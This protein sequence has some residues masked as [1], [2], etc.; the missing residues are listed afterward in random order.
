MG[1]QSNSRPNRNL[2]NA[3]S[4]DQECTG[5]DWCPE[6]QEQDATASPE[7]AWAAAL[8][9]RLAPSPVAGE[10]PQGGDTAPEYFKDSYHGLPPEPTAVRVDAGASEC[11]QWCNE[12]IQGNGVPA[13]L[14]GNAQCAG[15][16]FCG[17]DDPASNATD[18]NATVTNATD[19]VDQLA[20]RLANAA[21]AGAHKGGRFEET[22]SLAPRPMDAVS[23]AGVLGEPTPPLGI[24]RAGSDHE[25]SPER[26]L[27][28]RLVAREVAARMAAQEARVAATEAMAQKEAAQKVGAAAALEKEA[29]ERAAATAGAWARVSLEEKKEKK[30]KFYAERASLAARA[31]RAAM[32]GDV[33]V[34]GKYRLNEVI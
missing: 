15:C 33:P 21:M 10:P 23:M 9:G 18:M 19:S 11:K 16:D 3:P 24:T 20:K 12:M 4:P 22:S 5:C 31:E 29:A 14:C 26:A 25:Q 30:E 2:A 34:L 7:P 28:A 13:V 1:K 32:R 6:E 17:A 8:R 27:E